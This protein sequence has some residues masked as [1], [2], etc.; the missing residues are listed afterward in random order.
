[1]QTFITVTEKE[2]DFI[3]SIIDNKKKGSILYSKNINIIQP[4]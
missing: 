1:M 4:V 2:K 3:F